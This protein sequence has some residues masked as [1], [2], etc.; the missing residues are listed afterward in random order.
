MYIQ[1]DIYIYLDYQFIIN[2]LSIYIIL[3]PFSRL[4]PLLRTYHA[5]SIS[6]EITHTYA[7]WCLF[8]SLDDWVISCGKCWFQIP[9]L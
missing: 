7:P 4:A 3:Y 5:T 8:I 2:F 6:P 1:Y 9:A